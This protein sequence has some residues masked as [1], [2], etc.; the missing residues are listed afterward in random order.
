MHNDVSLLTRSEQ[1]A[2][3]PTR[4]VLRVENLSV[5]FGTEGDRVALQDVSFTIH[6]GEVVALVGESGCGKSLTAL[7]VMGLLPPE[8]RVLGGSV[9]VCGNEI[10]GIPERQL[11]RY[12]GA[13]MGMVFQDAMI[14]LNPLAAVGR[15]IDEALRI[16]TN[17]GR[18][19]RRA[20]VITLLEAVGVPDPA[21]RLRQLPHQFSGGLRQRI[22]IA[23]A[24]VAE[25]QL[26][27]ADEPTTAL[28]VT[29]QAQI[30]EVLKDITQ[31]RGT[32]VLFITHD[33]GVVAEIA[34]RVVVMYGGRV[35]ESADVVDTFATPAHPYTDALLHSVPR[36]DSARDLDLP[37]IP[38]NVPA[39]GAAPAGCPFRPRC[40]DA[41][42][43]CLTMPPLEPVLPGHLVACWHPHV[44]SKKRR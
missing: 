39:P 15:Q 2:A 6:S 14:A 32:A 42:Q 21:N 23:M 29:I 12:R 5:A 16:H 20:K 24:L 11:R 28:D 17:L 31:S 1:E 10:I 35:I 9:R 7:S 25:P 13:V 26:I 4:E 30:L 22:M 44:D 43:E 40:A 27:I 36:V 41:T 18:S 37:A 19:D 33:M 3:D 8:A 34:D 38:G